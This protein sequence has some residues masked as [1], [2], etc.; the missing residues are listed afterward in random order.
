MN[1]KMKIIIPLA[2]VLLL[3]ALYFALHR[4]AKAEASV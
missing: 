4:P 1:A 2:F 3:V